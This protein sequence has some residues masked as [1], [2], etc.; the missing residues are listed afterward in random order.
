MKENLKRVQRR[1]W[2]PKL[3]GDKPTMQQDA[4]VVISD[5]KR[6]NESFG[7][8]PASLNIKKCEHQFPQITSLKHCQECQVSENPMF[9]VH[10]VYRECFSIVGAAPWVP[11][12]H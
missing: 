3:D 4:M 11:G 7:P 5:W 10:Y 9:Y 6:I 12:T 8:K 2:L 1:R